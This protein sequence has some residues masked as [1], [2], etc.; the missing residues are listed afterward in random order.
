MVNN[1]YR[2]RDKDHMGVIVR[3]TGLIEHKYVPGAGWVMAGLMNH[4][5]FDESDRYDLYDKITEAEAQKLI[6]GD[7]S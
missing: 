1:Y 2:L 5:I 6:G 4:Y 7:A 3:T